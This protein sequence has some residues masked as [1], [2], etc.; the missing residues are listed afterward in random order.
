M[1]Y[2]IEFFEKLDPKLK[3]NWQ[4]LELESLNYCFQSYDWFENWLANYRNNNK[5]YSLCI[6][7]VSYQG[8][9]LCILPFEIE[10]RMNLRIL[11]WAGGLQADYFSPILNHYL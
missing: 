1:D 8:K 2:K 7:Q 3:E 11:Q 9:I 6:V 10:K 4:N 5:R